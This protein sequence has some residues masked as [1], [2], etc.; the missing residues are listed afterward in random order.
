MTQTAFPPRLG[1][2]PGTPA[3]APAP[4]GP[5]TTA[6]A[7]PG[8]ERDAFFDN[9]KLLAVVLVVAGH[10]WEPLTDGSRAA[11]ALYLLVYAFHMPAFIV[12]SGYFS[13]NFDS[14]PDRIQRL[15]T[16]IAIPYIVF[17][18]AYSVFKRYADDDPGHPVSLVDPWYLTWFL[19]ALFVWRLTAP[20]WRVVRWPLALAVALSVLATTSRIGDDLDLQRVFQFL[21][22][23]VLGLCL[24]PEHFAFLRRR[25]VRLAAVP[26]FVCALVVAHWAAPRMARAWMYHRDSAAELG[27]PVWQGVAMSLAMLVCSTALTAAFLALVPTRRTWL[28]GLG[29]GTLYAFLLHGFL[30]K[31]GRFWGWYDHAFVHTPLGAVTVTAIAVAVALLL[32]SP[33]VRAVFRPVVE[34]RLDWAFKRR[35]AA[36]GAGASADA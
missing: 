17:E 27:V 3:A 13:R 25:A 19:V 36:R 16:G 18:T 23:F 32:C 21:P 15:V 14:R 35:A 34:P 31:G 24:R 1:K 26:L 2:H 30:A 10:A 12:I 29:T 33:P 6:P 5:G 22:F 9:A 28:T 8:K 11:K 4:T 20:I 7:Q